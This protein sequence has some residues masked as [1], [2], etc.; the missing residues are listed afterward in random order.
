M[1]QRNS[2]RERTYLIL[3]DRI[4]PRPNQR[5]VIPDLCLT[6][7]AAMVG[8]VVLSLLF[9]VLRHGRVEWGGGPRSSDKVLQGQC[10]MWPRKSEGG[11]RGSSSESV[12]VDVDEDRVER[13]CRCQDNGLWMVIGQPRPVAK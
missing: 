5:R 3:G 6:E 4:V 7:L 1:A 2:W 10:G 13:S 9:L 12:D 8:P 11:G